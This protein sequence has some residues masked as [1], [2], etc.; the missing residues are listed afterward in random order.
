MVLCGNNGC[1]VYRPGSNQMKEEGRNCCLHC[2]FAY[3]DNSLVG[4]LYIVIEDRVSSVS[5]KKSTSK[6]C[7]HGVVSKEEREQ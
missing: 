4:F 3:L 5:G 6:Y 7:L 2:Y 1:D